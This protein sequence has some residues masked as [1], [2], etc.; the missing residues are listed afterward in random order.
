MDNYIS[1]SD[2]KELERLKFNAK[3]EQSEDE[4]EER[5]VR[6]ESLLS[7]VINSIKDVNS[8]EDPI[9]KRFDKLEEEHKTLAK[10]LISIV[11]NLSEIKEQLSNL[12]NNDD[13]PTVHTTRQTYNSSGSFPPMNS[14]TAGFPPPN[15]NGQSSSN[16]GNFPPP[17]PNSK[18]PSTQNTSGF[19]PP[20]PF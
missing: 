3:K 17:P 1:T 15:S 7:E 6:I 13:S 16:S 18:G 5:F 8:K 9:E 14:G 19:P 20:P 12:D 11:K 2:I 4:Y 10:A